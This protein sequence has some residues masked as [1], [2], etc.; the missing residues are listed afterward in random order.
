MT[1]PYRLSPARRLINLVVRPLARLGLTGPRTHLLTVPGRRTG[2]LWST[3]V[4]IV[5]DGGERYLVAPYGDRNWVRNARAAGWVELRRGR[6]RERLAVEELAPAE[7]VPV[8]RR[9]YELGRV[10]RPFFGVTLESSAEEW[11]AEAPRHP[12]FRLRVP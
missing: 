9:Y 11:L 12:V 3:P 6:R 2:K 8:L 7:A 10:T 5:R 4:S 1:K